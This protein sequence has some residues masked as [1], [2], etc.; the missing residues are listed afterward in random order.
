LKIEAG[1]IM[2]G[3]ANFGL[4]GILTDPVVGYETLAA[5]M[6]EH[7]VR[8]IQ[9]RMKDRDEREVRDT[10]EKLRR[11]IRSDSLFIVN[12]NPEIARDTGADGVHLGQDDMSFEAA[13][14][15]LRDDAVIGLSTHN[16]SQ[17]R[18]A[19]AKG[20][21]YIGV[22]PVFATPTKKVPDPV[23]GLD[24][25]REMIKAAT[26]PAVAIG[27]IDLENVRTV[28][29]NGANNVCAVRCINMARDPG[30]VLKKMLAA[31]ENA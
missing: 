28:L 26:C 8:Y 6:V 16:L 3:H 23:I 12:D 30:S 10:A 4:Y 5:V 21:N 13:R 29:A 14:E 19:C 27:G 2:N 7:R 11:I 18:I 25:M 20:P 24:G 9:L 1:D 31:F 22:G 15:I 17:T